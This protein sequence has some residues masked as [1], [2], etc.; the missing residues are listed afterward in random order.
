MQFPFLFPG[1][2]SVP[3]EYSVGDIRGLLYFYQNRSGTYGMNPSGRSEKGIT[4]FRDFNIKEFI[5]PAILK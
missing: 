2:Y 5:Q 3:V 4:C 1:T